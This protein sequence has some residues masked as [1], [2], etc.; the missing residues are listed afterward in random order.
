MPSFW[1][2]L[3]TAPRLPLR[4]HV[5]IAS[6]KLYV[7]T[8]LFFAV[9]VLYMLRYNSHKRGF[10]GIDRLHDLFL[11]SACTRLLHPRKHRGK[12]WCVGERRVRFKSCSQ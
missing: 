10:N 12:R 8:S 9:S 6:S 1:C 7:M 2:T 5:V 11:T 3:S 4:Q